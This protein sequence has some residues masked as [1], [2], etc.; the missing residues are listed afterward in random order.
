MHRKTSRLRLIFA[1]S[2]FPHEYSLS[3]HA[4]AFEAAKKDGNVPEQV[5]Q[6]REP[7]RFS[8]NTQ[9]ALLRSSGPSSAPAPR[10]SEATPQ[11]VTV[12][13]TVHY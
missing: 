5:A 7:M 3:L 10:I 4:R 12:Y 13:C 8:S 2:P 11:A 1:T 9:A 6:P